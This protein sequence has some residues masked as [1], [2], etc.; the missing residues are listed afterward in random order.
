MAMTLNLAKSALL[1]GALALLGAGAAAACTLR[2]PAQAARKVVPPGN[3]DLALLDA[4]V[5]AELNVARCRN[6][7]PELR[8]AGAPLT[9]TAAAHSRW[10]VSARTLTH[11]SNVGGRRTASDRIR[12]AGIRPRAGSENIGYVS[13]YQIDGRRFRILDAGSCSFATYGGQPL[14][15]HSYASLA[16]AMVANLMASR[17]H[18]RNILDRR[19]NRVATGAAFDAA[20]PHCGRIWFTQ[21]FVG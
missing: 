18:R 4:A 6:G 16:K 14:P 13:R 17:G 1:A 21:S 2:V 8:A 9:R 12:A 10:M 11:N 19:V 5:R 3:L 20:G 7:L 15:A